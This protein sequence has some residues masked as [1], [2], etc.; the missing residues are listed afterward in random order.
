MGTILSSGLLTH[1]IVKVVAV[2]IIFFG[3]D[4]ENVWCSAREQSCWFKLY[5]ANRI[6][7]IRRTP[8]PEQWSHVPGASNPAYLAIRGLPSSDLAESKV[9][10]A[11]LPS[12]YDG[13]PTSG[14]QRRATTRAHASSGS[15]CRN[16]DRSHYSIVLLHTATWLQLCIPVEDS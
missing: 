8:N 14:H 5:V 15:A 16:I 2:H 9:C 1:I 7:K 10:P 6:A 3:T 13:K 11:A 4:A 12:I